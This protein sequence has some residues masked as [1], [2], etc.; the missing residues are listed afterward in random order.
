MGPHV[1]NAFDPRAWGPSTN[2][3]TLEVTRVVLTTSLF[4]IGIELPQAYM[5]K[6]A[7]G[8]IAMVVPTMAVG[9]VI[10]AGEN[11]DMPFKSPHLTH[12]RRHLRII[13]PINVH[14]IVGDC[15]LFDSD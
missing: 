3:M 12:T 10:V 13:S 7:K 1:V 9:W 6:N 15:S 14:S 2:T 8:L 11:I 4:A 5:A